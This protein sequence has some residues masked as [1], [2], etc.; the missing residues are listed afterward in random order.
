[1]GLG[2]QANAALL[3]KQTQQWLQLTDNFNSA[4]KVPPL[5][6]LD[7]SLRIRIW[8]QEMGDVQNWASTIE[9]DIQTISTALEN[10][11]KC[12]IACFQS[13]W[14]QMMV[15]LLQPMRRRGDNPST[16]IHLFDDVNFVLCAHTAWSKGAHYPIS[17]LCTDLVLQPYTKVPIQS[18]SSIDKPVSSQ[19]RH[20]GL[21][22]PYGPVR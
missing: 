22:P 8:A 7:L 6:K 1:M 4:L 17:P 19:K 16:L 2:S 12:N 21:G 3:A 5:Q 18:K 10:A 11:Y 14:T 15:I 9:A 20:G 13:K